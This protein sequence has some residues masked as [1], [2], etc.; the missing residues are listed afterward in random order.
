MLRDLLVLVDLAMPKVKFNANRAGRQFVK[1]VNKTF[2]SAA[3]QDKVGNLVV[4]RIQLQARRGKPL[5]DTKSFPKLTKVTK[6]IR[7]RLGGINKTHPSF[8]P[9]KSHLTFTGQLIDAITF[10]ISR[11][12]GWI[13]FVDKSKRRPINLGKNKKEEKPPNNEKLSRDLDKRGFIL[14]TAKGLKS[15]VKLLARIKKIYLRF[16]RRQLRRT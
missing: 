9:S 13:F 11:R 10:S 3:L 15:D 1:D 8:R 5:N 12:T 7:K 2:K 6:K 14:F 4:E 16:L